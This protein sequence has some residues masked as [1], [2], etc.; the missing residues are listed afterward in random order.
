MVALLLAYRIDRY[1]YL[2]YTLRYLAED[3]AEDMRD[4]VHGRAS[5]AH[6]INF[7]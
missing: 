6:I 7:I 1:Y 2:Q 3:P 4:G 5:F